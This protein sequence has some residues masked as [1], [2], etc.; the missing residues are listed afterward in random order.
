MNWYKTKFNKQSRK[1]QIPGGL[2]DLKNKY[3]FNKIQLEK[4]KKVEM[5]HTD[6]ADIA[7]EIAMDHLTED[8]DYYK[9]L[10][11]IDTNH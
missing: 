4:G 2:A 3:D 1:D 9:K 6:D 10:E 7:E 11:K 8:P 5:E